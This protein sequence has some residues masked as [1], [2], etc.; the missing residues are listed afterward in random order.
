MK[1]LIIYG[2]GKIAAMLFHFIK[3]D[4]NVVAFCVDDHCIEQNTLEGMPVIPFEGI[5]EQ[6]ETDSHCMIIAVGFTEMNTIRCD[7]FYAARELGYELINYI[8]PSVSLN[9]V[10]I[11]INNIILDHVS[12]HPGCKIGDSNFISSNTNIGHGCIIND[13]CW[14]NAGVGLGGDVILDDN[15]FIGIN[16]T[17]SHGVVLNK[18]TFVGANSLINHDTEDKSVYLSHKAEKFRLNSQQFLSFSSSI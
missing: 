6:Y 4:F 11:G 7:R 9:N 14:I 15:C 12:I 2:N 1:K 10:E 18:E 17:I 16:A 13:N 5:T 8:H 3:N